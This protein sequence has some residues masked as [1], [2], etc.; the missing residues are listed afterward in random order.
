MA[1]HPDR[2]SERVPIHGAHQRW[3]KLTVL[4]SG[5][6]LFIERVTIEYTN[7][8]A[9]EFAVHQRIEAASTTDVFDL[10]ANYHPIRAVSVY[11][12]PESSFGHEL[13]RVHIYGWR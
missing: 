13:V 10:P 1:V 2:S 6:P 7:D 4:V 12:R 11:F 5:R 8:D 3:R 9:I